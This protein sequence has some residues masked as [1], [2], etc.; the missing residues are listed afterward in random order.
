MNEIKN[1]NISNIIENSQKHI[2]KTIYKYLFMLMKYIFIGKENFKNQTKRQDLV[3]KLNEFT[4]YINKNIIIKEKNFIKIQPDSERCSFKNFMNIINFV[5]SQNLVYAGN[6]LE[7]I[8][9]FI[10]NYSCETSKEDN[11]G[12]FINKNFGKLRGLKND[13]LPDW[14]KKSEDIFSIE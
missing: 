3:N 1:E 5:K 11:F 13:D 6:I 4:E 12:K 8:L 9:I 14:F 10:F 7:G 2:D